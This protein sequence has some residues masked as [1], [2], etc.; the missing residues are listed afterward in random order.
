MKLV[1]KLLERISGANQYARL[2]VHLGASVM[3]CLY[4]V[5]FFAFTIAPG[6]PNYFRAMAIYRGAL[7]AAPACLAAGICAAVICDLLYRTYGPKDD[8]TSKDDM[9]D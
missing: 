7:E 6:M 4:I 2:A 8:D 3:V 1:Q 5:A 9:R